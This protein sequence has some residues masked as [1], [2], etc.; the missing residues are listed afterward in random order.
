MQIWKKYILV[1]VIKGKII[2]T[3]DKVFKHKAI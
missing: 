3:K 2:K 1:L